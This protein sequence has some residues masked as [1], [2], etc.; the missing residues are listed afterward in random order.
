[1]KFIKSIYAG[2]MTIK[3]IDRCL[4]LFMFILMAQSIYG[5]FAAANDSQ[6]AASIDVVIRTTSSAIFG[7]FLSANFN[8]SEQPPDAPAESAAP[9]AP[10]TPVAPRSGNK[11]SRVQIILT[12]VIGVISLVIIL[13]ARNFIE[14]TPASVPAITHLRDFVSGCVGFLVGCPVDETK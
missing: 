12:T 1:M 2:F 4:I 9:S 6:Y 14:L 3:L 13:I 8:K 7:Y 5:I 10:S 11:I